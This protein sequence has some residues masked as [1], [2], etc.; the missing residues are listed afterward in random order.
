MLYLTLITLFAFGWAAPGA[1]QSF[2]P[3]QASQ[4]A[5][6]QQAAGTPA[7]VIS[8]VS[9]EVQ[10]VRSG[11]T[12][13]LPALTADLLSVGDRVITGRH[14]EATFL[15]CP[16][17]RSATLLEDSEVLLESAT[18][19]LRKGKL[20]PDRKL[21][22]CHLPATLALAAPSQMQAGVMRLRGSNL[23]LVSPS[24]IS[25]ATLQPH[26]RWEPVDN[27]TEYILKLMDRE[28]RVLWSKTLS[29]TD[30]EY[31]ADAPPLAWEQKYWWR[32][33]AR[34]G[35][36]TLME[37]G[38]YFQILPQWQADEVRQDETTLRSVF[39]ENA[40][41]ISPLF[42]LAFLYDQHNMLDQAAKIYGELSQ[43]IRPQ[44]WVQARI[45]E[46]MNKMGWD[47]LEPGK[48]Q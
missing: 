16:E 4:P 20:G 30:A 38:S 8:M 45:T 10:I 44:E 22:S 47:R 26:F 15:F 17:S 40:R 25:I 6:N 19:R 41:D 27:A 23:I 37:A 24:R 43:K 11:Q 31:P 14:S 46:L 32:V 36:D 13:P 3:A 21:P 5:S 7:G 1:S 9:G 2:P 28:E 39:A 33:A 48:S 29:S 18:V 35:D 42:S 12:I 34:D